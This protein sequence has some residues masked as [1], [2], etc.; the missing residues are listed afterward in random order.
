[1]KKTLRLRLSATVALVSIAAILPLPAVE[2]VD[3][4][5]REVTRLLEQDAF[6]AAEHLANQAVQLGESTLAEQDPVFLRALSNLALACRRLGD[7]ERAQAL[8]ERVLK[9]QEEVLGPDHPD[10][11]GSLEDL[12]PV[13]R[14]LQEFDRAELMYRRALELR[15]QAHGPDD[16]RLIEALTSLAGL[17]QMR[18]E[19]AEAKPLVER[20]IGI[21]ETMLGPDH[22]D[23]VTQLKFMAAISYALQ[24]AKGGKAFMDRAERIERAHPRVVPPAEAGRGAIGITVT[25]NPSISGSLGGGKGR[26][27]AAR[28]YFVRFDAA[29]GAFEQA[30]DIWSASSWS[31]RE[32]LASSA[33]VIVASNFHRGADVYLINAEPGRYVAVGALLISE[34]PGQ[35][36]A[37]HGYFST[38]IAAR[39]EVFVTPGSF[40]FMGDVRGAIRGAPDAL[41][42]LSLD[43]LPGETQVVIDVPDLGALSHRTVPQWVKFEQSNSGGKRY[44]GFWKRTRKTFE[45]DATWLA[46]V[47]DPAAEAPTDSK[48]DTALGQANQRALDKLSSGE[49]RAALNVAKRV[50]QICE[51]SQAADPSCL[52]P[53]L[54][55]L[56]D[57]SRATRDPAA[58]R[59]YYDRALE[60]RA[61]TL[62]PKHPAV[63]FSLLSLAS[64]TYEQDDPETAEQFK[65]RALEILEESLGPDHPCM[66]DALEDLAGIFRE[67]ERY[68]LAADMAERVLVIR[69]EALGWTHPMIAPPLTFLADES[70]RLGQY[71][72][73]VSLMERAVAIHE[74]AL[75]PEHATVADALFAL[76]RAYERGGDSAAAVA[77]FERALPIQRDE[78]DSLDRRIVETMKWLVTSYGGLGNTEKAGQLND[79]VQ[80]MCQQIAMKDLDSI[81]AGL[82]RYAVENDGYPALS[83]IGALREL[84]QPVYVRSVPIE[85]AWGNPYTVRSGADSYELRSLGRNGTADPTVG[86]ETVGLDA[87]IV[88]SDGALIQWPALR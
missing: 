26:M 23:L 82:A 32:T 16:P 34:I 39:T 30:R 7:N 55:N 52:G 15:E 88:F 76:G 13:Y 65:T 21:Q 5:N 36:V 58:A 10:L 9:I 49:Y 69:E 66:A 84:L 75:G 31:E 44:S 81:G 22:P 33:P 35:T 3:R 40:G 28:V 78:Y 11:A 72:R 57:L 67:N 64:L 46:L 87:D 12:G 27:Y 71:E 68:D 18:R 61:R 45:H 59:E 8:Y 2:D 4:I 56:A 48:N 17:Y 62:G 29:D 14:S 74:L 6:A 1:V 79:R 53:A 73:A 24:D 25:V 37:F 20:V 41:Q 54:M 83:D 47:P 60:Q 86:G 50:L 51:S 42:Q 85:D 38:E 19:F 77:K 63:A 70:F 80:I 43:R